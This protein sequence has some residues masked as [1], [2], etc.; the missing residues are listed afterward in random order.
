[1]DL[2][3]LLSL[4]MW[5]SIFIYCPAWLSVAILTIGIVAIINRSGDEKK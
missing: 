4:T 3:M 2:E 5:A 1:M